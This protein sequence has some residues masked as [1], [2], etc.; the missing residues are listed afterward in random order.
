[1]NHI[2][3]TINAG[4]SSLKMSAFLLKGSAEAPQKIAAACIRG[5]NTATTTV[6]YA[7]Y[8]ETVSNDITFRPKLDWCEALSSMLAIL[9]QDPELREVHSTDD[10]RFV[11]HRI[12]HGKGFREPQLIDQKLFDAL[13]EATHLAP[14][15]SWAAL[16]IV[17]LCKQQFQNA[18]NIA[19]FDTQF[20]VTIPKHIYTYPIDQDVAQQHGLRKYGFHGLSYSYLA[21]SVCKFLGTDQAATNLIALHLGSGASV[22]AIQN[23]KSLD[24]SMGL[25]PLSGLFG[26]TRSGTIDPR[27]VYDCAGGCMAVGL[28]SLVSESI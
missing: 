7:R 24:T 4:S 14:L 25:T 5:I 18:A 16:T 6:Y 17:A 19:C 27:Y 28:Q 1:M 13:A 22:C 12:V 3:L 23:G 21:R 26:A 8:H 10:I 2:L 15:H 20:H 9:L 11:C